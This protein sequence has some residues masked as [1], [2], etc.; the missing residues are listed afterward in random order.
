MT[1]SFRSTNRG[2]PAG[3]A[4]GDGVASRA[5]SF[6]LQVG[7]SLGTQVAVLVLGVAQAAVVAR[8]LGPDGKGILAIAVLVSIVLNSLLNPGLGLSF[9]YHTARGRPSAHQLAGQSVVFASAAGGAALLVT[10]IGL[11]TGVLQRII[12]NVSPALLVIAVSSVPILVMID[13]LRG[14]VHGQGRIYAVNSADV[15]RKGGQL[16]LTAVA[17]I[18]LGLGVGGAVVAWVG[19][20][21][22]TL[23]FL[24]HRVRRGGIRLAPRIDRHHMRRVLGYGLRAHAANLAQFFNY[25]LDLFLVNILVGAATVGIYTVSVQ[26]AELVFLVPNAAA[27][28]LFPRLAGQPDDDRVRRMLRVNAALTLAVAAGL[29]AFGRPMIE[30]VFSGAFSAAYG[31]LLWLLPGTILIGMSKILSSDLAARGHPQYNALASGV[32]LV[33]TLLLDV[34]LIPRH[35]AIGAAIASS[36]AY[37]VSFT[38][39]VAYWLRMRASGMA[40][41]DSL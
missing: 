21:A 3:D 30:T 34:L 33:V 31:P 18:A 5:P 23:A 8:W 7:S 38:V 22:V 39:V 10:A 2:A 29:V 40:T 12:P 17:V 27:F 4:R 16:A 24:I 9:A 28:V 37:T 11:A 35:G 19:A 13:Q 1:P 15:L 41:R 14:I 36:A 20:V 32:G 26:I 25:R 6:T